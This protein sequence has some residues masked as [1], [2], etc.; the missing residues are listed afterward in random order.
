VQGRIQP[1]SLGGAISVIFGSKSHYEFTTARDM[2][3]TF[4]TL[5]GQNNGRQNGL[6]IAN[7]VFRIVQNLGETSNFRKF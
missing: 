2:K 3:D 5:L 1:V 6:I 4:T 7:A